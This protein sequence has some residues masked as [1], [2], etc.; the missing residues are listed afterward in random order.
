MTSRE[1]ISANL[2]GDGSAPRCGLTFSGQRTNDVLCLGP[3]R[4]AGYEPR[5]W[6][7][8]KLEYYDDEWGNLWSRM[9]GGCQKGEIHQPVLTDWSQL[10]ELRLPD[11]TQPETWADMAAAFAAETE[12]YRMAAIGGWIFDN[13]RYLRRL[14]VYLLDMGLYP[15]ELGRL[16]EMVASV[17]ETKIRAAAAAGADGIL[18]G[19]DLGTQTGPLFSPGM[20]RSYFK[21][22][23]TRLLGIAHEAGMAV[24]LHSC[25]QNWLLIDDLCDCGVDVFQFDQ[26]LV[27]DLDALAAKLKARGAALWSPVDIQQVLPTGDRELI[28]RESRRMVEAFRGHLIAKN[29]PDLP[30]IGVAAEWDQWAYEAMVAANG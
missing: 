21:P 5:R 28:E 19:E 14:E 25:G 13:A 29:Y 9:V 24:W 6:V 3:R 27:Y 26:P 7:E 23:Y 12:R 15:D 16:H 18:I 1:V 17:Y 30:G 11:Y 4:P 8:G 20:F 2:A 22:L 10:D